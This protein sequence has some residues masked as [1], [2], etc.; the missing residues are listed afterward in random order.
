MEQV[1]IRQQNKSRIKISLKN[2]EFG[3]KRRWVSL[4]QR[5]SEPFL[6]PY[7][8]EATEGGHE[9]AAFPKLICSKNPEH[10]K[11]SL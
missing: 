11:C 3:G 8:F 5:I 4:L 9:Y 7:G 6:C 10:H 2:A 1:D